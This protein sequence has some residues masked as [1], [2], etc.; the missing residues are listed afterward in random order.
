MKL[1]YI[2]GSLEDD[3]ALIPS[4]VSSILVS[5]LAGFKKPFETRELPYGI[6]LLG[7]EA[8]GYVMSSAHKAPTFMSKVQQKWGRRGVRIRDVLDQNL[9]D[10]SINNHEKALSLGMYHHRLRN[11][12]IIQATGMPVAVLPQPTCCC[13]SSREVGAHLAAK[14]CSQIVETMRFLL[15]RGQR[16]RECRVNAIGEAIVPIVPD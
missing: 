11:P 13:R 2:A 5:T 16:G 8:L 12:F 10:H 15:H 9:T 1:H 6:V 3:L 7:L 4:T 14:G